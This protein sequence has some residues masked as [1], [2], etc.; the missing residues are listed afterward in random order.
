MLEWAVHNGSAGDTSVDGAL[1]H[2]RRKDAKR[3]ARTGRD[4]LA[5]RGDVAL[6]DTRTRR[7]RRRTAGPDP[8][9]DRHRAHERHAQRRC[10]S[11]RLK[12]RT[13]RIRIRDLQT[14]VEREG[15]EAECGRPRVRRKPRCRGCHRGRPQ[16]KR[17]L[18]L[19]RGRGNEFG[20][21]PER[22]LPLH[23]PA[24]R[25]E[26]AIANASRSH[27]TRPRSTGPSTPTT[28]TSKNANSRSRRRSPTNQPATVPACRSRE[29]GGARSRSRAMRAGLAEHTIYYFRVIGEEQL[30]RPPTAARR[31]H[32]MTPPNKPSVTTDTASEVMRTSATRWSS[33][34]S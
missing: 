8:D 29:P 3:T 27:A 13:V 34:R 5:T 14:A 10:Q 33:T 6:P 17:H 1:P 22:A 26:A 12:R 11:E 2:G 30:R 23:D 7:S 15:S 19:P 32:F 18:L 4:R 24:D 9:G 25:A 20:N 31:L 21:E 28:R 16:R